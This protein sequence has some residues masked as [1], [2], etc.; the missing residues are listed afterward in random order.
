[1]GILDGLGETLVLL[2]VVGLDVNLEVH[3]H[4]DFPLLLAQ[5]NPSQPVLENKYFF[6]S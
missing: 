1:M 6:T 4:N 3:H 2:R 5:H